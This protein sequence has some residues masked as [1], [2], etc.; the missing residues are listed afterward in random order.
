MNPRPM[1]VRLSRKGPHPPD[2]P[3]RLGL[4]LGGVQEP[5]VDVVVQLLEGPHG[6]AGETRVGRRG[7]AVVRIRLIGT[8]FADR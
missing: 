6:T 8:V 4:L 5:V 7:A 3:A 2:S 1:Y